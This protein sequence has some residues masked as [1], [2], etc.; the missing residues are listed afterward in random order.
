MLDLNQWIQERQRR[1]VFSP[2]EWLTAR[3]G[4]TDQIESLDAAA[5]VCMH[6]RGMISSP[7]PA[8]PWFLAGETELLHRPKF[9]VLYMRKDK[10]GE[11]MHHVNT[12][13]IRW[14]NGELELAGENA[15]LRFGPGWRAA[16]MSAH[17]VDFNEGRD[18]VQQ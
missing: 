2:A 3:I 6:K 7:H 14:H 1:D 16:V 12:A 9:R 17:L 15:F 4:L 8:C 11:P 5:P 18:E 10:S 13:W